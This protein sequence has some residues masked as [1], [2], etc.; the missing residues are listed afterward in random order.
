MK[1]ELELTKVNLQNTY[2]SY[3]ALEVAIQSQIDYDWDPRS[4]G[5]D[6]VND[7]MKELLTKSKDGELTQSLYNTMEFLFN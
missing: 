1:E 2:S 6:N 4:L 7:R 3:K 5:K